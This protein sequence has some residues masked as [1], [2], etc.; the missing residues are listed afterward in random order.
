MKTELLFKIYSNAR[1]IN[2]SQVKLP[3]IKDKYKTITVKPIRKHTNFHLF[4]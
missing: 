3:V 2:H 4:G 1:K